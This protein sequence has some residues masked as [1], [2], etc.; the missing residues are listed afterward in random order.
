MRKRRRF[1]PNEKAK[2]ALE[3][4]KA[5]LTMSEI[6]AKYEIHATQVNVWKKQAI[7]QLPSLF[8]NQT[9]QMVTD[10]SEELKTLYE[11][12]GRLSI[13]NEFLKKKV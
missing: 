12:I 4:I 1:S 5:E 6:V 2:I 8:S 11:Q 9:K 13:E 3:A 10:H 7:E